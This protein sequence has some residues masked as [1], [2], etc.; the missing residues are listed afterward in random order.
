MNRLFC[1]LYLALAILFSLYGLLLIVEFH[2]ESIP[3]QTSKTFW[4]AV[5]GVAL[6]LLAALVFNGQWKL[7]LFLVLV[8]LGL[9]EFTLQ[10]AA[11]FGVLP[12][13]N[14]KPK[15]PYARI[16]WT[17]EGRG[18]SIRNRFGW[19]YPAFDLAAPRQIA[20]VGD[21]MVEAM[22]VPRDRNHA[23][24]LQQLLKADSPNY[25]VLG[26][27]TH[28]TAPA[29]YIEVLEYAHRHFNPREA[30]VY[31]SIGSDVT[32][33][34]PALNHLPPAYYI[35]YDLDDHNQLVLNPGS[36]GAR[37][38]FIN[39]LE[40]SHHSVFLC[41]P[42]IL[43]SYCMTL[44]TALSIRDALA[45]RRARAARIAAFTQSGPHT[46]DEIAQAAIGFNAASFAVNPSPEVHRAISVLEAEVLK[47]QSLCDQWGI[48]LHL[49]V[50]PV[51]PPDFYRTQSGRDWSLK[52]G[53]H[54]FA[55]P[56]RELA[57]FAADH[58]IQAFDLG[59][60][61]Q[62]HRLPVDEIHSFYYAGGSGHFTEAGHRFCADAVYQAFYPRHT[63]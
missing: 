9:L 53:D 7:H 3:L 41:L 33:C 11:L 2:A 58:H 34:S 27:G 31:I 39:S 20:A 32:E 10:A 12:A 19:Y 52:I 45:M 35:Y 5:F 57:A 37:E 48:P 18:N 42:R 15:L 14:S 16:Y 56:G 29:H 46:A 17:S 24:L 55:G 22:E 38:S 49:V 30:I 43:N 36:V 62:S 61:M 40:L 6:F 13:V 59:A 25:A 50:L 63:H 4:G 60:Y 26:L 23:F 47:C 51:F 8:T 44:Q 21:S 54:D 1:R 28:G